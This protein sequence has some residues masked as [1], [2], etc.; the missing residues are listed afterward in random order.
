M[1]LNAACI[2]VSGRWRIYGLHGALR[3]ALFWRLSG[4]NT[5]GCV[6]GDGCGRLNADPIRR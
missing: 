6:V 4:M 3:R 1:T 2:R 5:A